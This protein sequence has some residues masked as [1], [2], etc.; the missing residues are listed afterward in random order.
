MIT[1]PICFVIGAGA[2]KC[3]E[4]PLGKELCAMVIEELKDNGQ[5][6][7][8]LLIENTAFSPQEIENFRNELF[9]SGQNSVDAFLETRREY[10]DVGKAAMS[11]ILL[12]YEQPELLWRFAIVCVRQRLSGLL[13]TKYPLL[14]LISID[15][16]NISY[17]P[18]S[19]IPMGRVRK[20]VP[21]YWA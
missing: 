9:L 6:T 12:R 2:S 3:Y 11:T 20:T 16:L 8:Q 4:F 18:H 7:R 14:L 17:S 21:R 13:T 10:L 5:K 15:L 19:C 1:R